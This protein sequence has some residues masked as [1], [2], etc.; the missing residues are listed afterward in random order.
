MYWNPVKTDCTTFPTGLIETWDVLKWCSAVEENN[1]GRWLIETW[2]VLKFNPVRPCDLFPGLIETWDVLK[3]A[4]C[5]AVTN[6]IEWLIETW[7]VLKYTQPRFPFVVIWIN[8][9][10][11]CIEICYIFF[12]H[13]CDLWL[14]ETWDVLKYHSSSATIATISD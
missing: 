7:D 12:C 6:S 4:S 3:S 13:C 11:R 14:I 1:T 5:A 8:R 9:N 2:D 10:M